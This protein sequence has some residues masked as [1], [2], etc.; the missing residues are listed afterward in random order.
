MKSAPATEALTQ[1]QS[2]AHLGFVLTGVV[3][4]LLGP[5]LPIITRTWHLDDAQ[6]GRLFAAQFLGAIL[7]TLA[8]S[9]VMNAIGI[10]RTAML[11]LLLMS[12]G[13]TAT[14]LTDAR[15]GA[16]A[17]VCYGVGL[18]F[19][20]PAI[21]LWVALAN[22]SRSAAALN[23]VNASWC[24]GAASGAPL[25]IYLAE[26]FG[27][28]R[29]LA[30]V[31]I[32]LALTAIAGFVAAGFSPASSP[33]T[34]A[35]PTES[36]QPANV[37]APLSQSS[38][39]LVAVPIAPMPRLQPS[40]HRSFIV[41]ICAFLFFYVGTENGIGGWAATY[42]NRLHILAASRI[43]FA[44]SIFYGALL[45]G[46]VLAPPILRRITA[47][48][49]L[50][51][52]LILGAAGALLFTLSTGPLTVLAGI[53]IAGIGLAPLFPVT[54]SIYSNE[55][56]KAATRWA[57]LIFAVGNLGGATFPWLIGRISTSTHA[58]RNGMLV[59][60]VCIAVMLV[61]QSRLGR[62]AR[63]A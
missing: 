45:V 25:I 27:L 52:G 42:A 34:D 37:V 30:A 28:T 22:P 29:T 16:L 61:V 41:L 58:L 24:I 56:G 39:P 33:T 43:G 9:R 8:S 23:L 53:C 32:L 5:I 3:N 31:G 18:G 36:A 21:N 62:V 35:P 13:V 15:F 19:V 44:E 63:S 14:G 20:V 49:L 57:G 48:R 12:A 47:I 26:K 6:A 10:R 2:I 50:L 1:A 54:V 17:V 38:Q 60:L 59:P 55:L 4:T 46:R 11:G 40:A 51:A 7:G